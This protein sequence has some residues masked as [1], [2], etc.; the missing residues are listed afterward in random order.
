VLRARAARLA[1]LAAAALAVNHGLPHGYNLDLQEE[2]PVL[3]QALLDTLDDLLQQACDA[4]DN[5]QE[6][7]AA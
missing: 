5:E 6:A 4:L 1:G 2:N 7:S 3:Y